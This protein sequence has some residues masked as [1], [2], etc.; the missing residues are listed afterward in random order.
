MSI[1][2]ASVRSSPLEKA[3]P[4]VGIKPILLGLSSKVI[5]SPF[6]LNRAKELIGDHKPDIL[7]FMKDKH[8]PL[9][10]FQKLKKISPK[11][12]FVMWYGDQR[13]NVI[14]P[15]ICG[16][17]G[18]LDA[19]FI[20]NECPNQFNTYNKFGIK[21]IRNFYHSFDPN[22]FKLFDTPVK[23]Q[24]FFGGSRFNAKKF[25]LCTLRAKLINRVR[26][27]Y[28]MVVHGG[29]WNFPTEKWVLRTTYA[30]ELRKS[31]TNL[32]INHYNI[33]RY[34]NRR[35]FESVASGRLH[36]TY[37][38]PGMEKHFKNKQHLVW[39]KTID[40][41]IELINFYLKHPK[42][43]KRIAKNGRDFFIKYHSWPTRIKQLK[44][45]L[46]SIL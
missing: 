35:L 16:R 7:W 23:Y 33:T 24:V 32:G 27:K 6:H 26:Q 10:F 5:K 20:T 36:I 18:I 30:K 38:I 43:M 11:T 3:L 42:E 29:G 44:K 17:R 13:G 9:K 37:Y 19:L 2:V 22:E 40:Q 15:L 21:Q 8:I 46:E 31:W 41:A 12:K 39:F 4:L 45:K 34:Y 28:K 1:K 14:P 25:P